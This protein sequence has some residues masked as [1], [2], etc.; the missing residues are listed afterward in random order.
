MAMKTF[1]ILRGVSGSG[2]STVAKLIEDLALGS[3]GRCVVGTAD[4][5]FMKDGVYKFNKFCLGKAHAACKEKI[6]LAMSFNVPVIVLANTNTTE[7][8]IKPYIEL[9]NKYNYKIISL[10]VE[11]RHGNKN[12]HD[13]PENTLLQQEQNIKGSLKL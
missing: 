13:V 7:K 3:L 11:N 8:D 2:K 6:D 12:V 4:D 9:A 5:Y 10:V 1:I